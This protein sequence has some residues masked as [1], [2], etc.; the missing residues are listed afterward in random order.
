ME[1]ADLKPSYRWGCNW[2]ELLLLLL[3]VEAA[4]AVAA[5]FAVAAAIVLLE[6]LLLGCIR[7]RQGLAPCWARP[8]WLLAKLGGSAKHPGIASCR[9]RLG[10]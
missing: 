5:D 2:V 6:K 3:Q 10:G 8:T 1:P 4:D 7:S 9:E